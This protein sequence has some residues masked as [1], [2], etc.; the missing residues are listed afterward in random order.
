[1]NLPGL[2]PG[3]FVA[4]FT[5]AHGIANGLGAVL[6]AA[7]ELKRRGR[8]DIKCVL[9]GDGNQ[10]DTLIART[11]SEGLD[12]CLFFPPVKKTEIARITA[13]FDCGLQ[14][15]ADVPAFYYGTSPNKFFDYLA[16]GLP[17]VNNYPGWL[18]ELIEAHRCGVVVPP[19]SPEAFADAL[20]R[21]ADD[22][23]GRRA[24]G[25]AARRL[26]EAEFSRA[27]L[28]NEFAAALEACAPGQTGTAPS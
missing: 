28:A 6:D 13:S 8:R 17:V 7:A 3:D 23:A 12:N 16:S 21:L 25:A 9:V 10:K 15:L 5:G 27:R 11:R 26:G 20:V 24:M 22:P 14:I 19:R 4:G 18:A 1:L 2:A